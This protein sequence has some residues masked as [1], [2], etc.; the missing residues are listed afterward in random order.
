MSKSKAVNNIQVNWDFVLASA[1]NNIMMG[2]ATWLTPE[3]TLL[4]EGDYMQNYPSQLPSFQ[5]NLDAAVASYYGKNAFVSGLRFAKTS[6]I[7]NVIINE[8]LIET[9]YLPY[10]CVGESAGSIVQVICDLLASREEAYDKKHLDREK[11]RE[12]EERDLYYH[13]RRKFEKVE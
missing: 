5:D 6:I 2:E 9:L 11:T 13:L 8:D 10:S 7:A 12:K 1:D 4:L 3:E